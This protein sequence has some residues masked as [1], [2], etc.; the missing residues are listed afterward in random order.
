MVIKIAAAEESFPKDDCV[1]SSQIYDH[2][3]LDGK[4]DTKVAC[5]MKT[6]ISNC[7]MEIHCCTDGHNVIRILHPWITNDKACWTISFLS[8]L[9]YYSYIYPYSRGCIAES[10]E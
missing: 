10:W 8:V 6:V 7:D 4:A 2:V 3:I 1:I 9:P 5:G